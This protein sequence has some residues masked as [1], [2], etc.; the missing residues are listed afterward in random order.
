MSGDFPAAMSVL[1]FVWYCEAGTHIGRT[2]MSACSSWNR[3]SSFSNI[4][5]SGPTATIQVT[6]PDEASRVLPRAS[7][8]QEAANETMSA[9]A[10][11]GR[12]RR[13][14]RDAVLGIHCNLWPFCD[15]PLTLGAAIVPGRLGPP[16][17]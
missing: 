14:T 8:S 17:Q 3:A 9:I 13:M 15:V 16:H 2:R 7:L 10:S 6:A 1:S 11:D 12:R 5:R 4:G